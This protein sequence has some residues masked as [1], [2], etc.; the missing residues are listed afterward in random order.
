MSILD[1]IVHHK[2]QEVEENK[3]LYPLD[4]LEKSIY[5]SSPTVSLTKYVTRSDKL[6]IIAEFK[7]KSPSKPDINAYADVE[8]VSIGYM[9]AGA[10]A[11]SILTDNHFFG[12]SNK[13]LTIARNFNF[14]PIL[15]KDFI[16]D[17]YQ[18][19]EA[20]SIGADAIL[21]IAEIL[22]EEEVKRFTKLAKS[23][24]MEV[25]LEIHDEDQLSKYHSSIDLIGVNNRD[26]KTFNTS[27]KNSIRLYEKLPKDVVKISES[28][29]HNASQIIELKECGFDGY[30]I[31]ENF[32]KI[33]D[34]AR[35]CNQLVKEVKSLMQQQAVRL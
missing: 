20:R 30:L 13:D 35:A 34:P 8:A 11:L 2:K 14:C 32:M 16:V 33:S 15:R 18:I 25:L 24:G 5:F 3:K 19:L 22:S 7:K 12:G 21:L 31:G 23:L 10:S 26:L 29:I 6:G 9:Q 27:I 4:L 1:I 28:G 17:E